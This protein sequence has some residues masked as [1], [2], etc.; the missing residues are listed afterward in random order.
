MASGLHQKLS[1]KHGM[2]YKPVPTPFPRLASPEPGP[3]DNRMGPYQYAIKQEVSETAKAEAPGPA[4]AATPQKDQEA[5]AGPAMQSV[6]GPPA[7]PKKPVQMPG[8]AK[9]AKAVKVSKSQSEHKCGLCG[10]AQFKGGA[11]RG[12]ICFRDLAKSA[13]VTPDGDGYTLEF[14]GQDWDED[15]IQ[16]LLEALGG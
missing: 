14:K 4:H 16:T 15:A 1:A 6:K 12:C 11:F 10:L 13:K 3:Y 8:M 9:P 2:D 5:P 7:A